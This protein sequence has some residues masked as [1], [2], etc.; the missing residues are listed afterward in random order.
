MAESDVQVVLTG[1]ESP[2]TR[3][4]HDVVLSFWKFKTKLIAFSD[5]LL[6]EMMV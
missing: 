4:V 3:N 6:I 1:K 5:K 2:G